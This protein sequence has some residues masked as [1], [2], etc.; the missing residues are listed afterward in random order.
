MP[1]DCGAGT[2]L[3]RY[4]FAS[5]SCPIAVTDSTWPIRP[6]IATDSSGSVACS[7][8]RVSPGATVSRFVPSES[9][10]R[11][12][13]GRLA[14]MSSRHHRHPVIDHPTVQH[15]HLAGQVRRD[16]ALVGD[17]DDGRTGLME[18]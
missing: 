10:S 2:L 5:A 15:G 4:T 9:S 12:S 17:H 1:P 14:V 6:I 13:F 11:S 18:I 3:V 16:H 7:P 8:K